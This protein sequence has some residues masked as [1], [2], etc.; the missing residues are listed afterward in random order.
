MI[1]AVDFFLFVRGASSYFS[2]EKEKAFENTKEKKKA[3]KKRDT[4]RQ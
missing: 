1:V 3:A 4:E 2:F